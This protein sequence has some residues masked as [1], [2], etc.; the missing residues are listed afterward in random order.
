MA[1]LTLVHILDANE[2]NG[3]RRLLWSGLAGANAE[4]VGVIFFSRAGFLTPK[5]A[6]VVQLLPV[7]DAPIPS[8]AGRPRTRLRD[9]LGGGRHCREITAWVGGVGVEG[10]SIHEHHCA[11]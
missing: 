7:I 8:A 6:H 2:N 1:D 3:I 11:P 10:R 5:T 4:D 9:S